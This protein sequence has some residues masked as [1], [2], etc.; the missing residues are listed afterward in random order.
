VLVD[1]NGFA[2]FVVVEVQFRQA[3]EHGLAMLVPKSDAR[4][5]STRF[6]PASTSFPAA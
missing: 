5:M 6:P 3:H 2:V 4:Q 1:G